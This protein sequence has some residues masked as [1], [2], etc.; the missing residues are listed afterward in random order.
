M[1]EVDVLFNGDAL[2]RR[3]ETTMRVAQRR[4]GAAAP[5]SDEQCACGARANALARSAVDLRRVHVLISVM[6]LPPGLHDADAVDAPT[7]PSLAI[8][9]IS[10]DAY[11]ADAT[12]RP[13]RRAM[14]PCRIDVVRD[15][16]FFRNVL[17]LPM[18]RARLHRNCA[19]PWRKAAHYVVDAC[20]LDDDDDA[21]GDGDA[22]EARR[23]AD[24]ALAYAL[25]THLGAIEHAT[26]VVAVHV[27]YDARTTDADAPLPSELL[28]ALLTRNEMS[29]LA[30]C[31]AHRC[32]AQR[33]AVF[34]RKQPPPQ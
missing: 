1:C 28:D 22:D 24:A 15:P 16:A 14:P 33:R 7:P 29:P 2:F 8:T 30:D 19:V 18:T 20:E 6:L 4:A 25:S 17:P 10:V 13:M 32:G 31:R 26:R 27:S 9:R 11:I 34:D 21:D 12:Q 23:D 5:S 3:D